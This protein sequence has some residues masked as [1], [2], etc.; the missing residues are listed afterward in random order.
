MKNAL[1]SSNIWKFYLASSLSYFIFFEPIIKIFFLSNDLTIFKIAMLGVIWNVTRLI[2]EVPSGIVADRWGRKNVLIISSL[3]AIL[4]LVVLINVTNYGGFIAAIILSS[5]SFAFLSGTDSAFFYDSLKEMKKEEEYEKLWARQ[6]IFKQI[7]LFIAFIASGFLFNISEV[8]PFQ[9]SLIF[10][11]LSLGIVFTYKEPKFTKHAEEANIFSHFTQA[12]SHIF[13]NPYLKTLMIFSLIYII[14]ADLSYTYGQIYLDH[15]MLPIIL[16][17]IVYTFK[18][19]FFTVA[20]NFAHK[21][22]NK[23]SYGNMFGLQLIM[24]IILLYAM[25]ITNN[26]IIGSL[27]FALIAVPYGFFIIL[28]SGYVNKH[29]KSHNRATVESM[30]SFLGALIIVVLEPIT[31]FLADLY[32]IKFPFLLVSFIMTLYAVYFLI[33]GR[34]R[35]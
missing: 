2:L 18:S 25:V 26:Y 21:L 17:G 4:Q 22:R 11:I 6:H 29:T 10:M 33:Y 15:L 23:Y 7:P 20:A 5:A 31:G 12:I 3:L 14:G 28:K 9:L 32:T 30:F 13:K 27:C 35:L 8:L 34:K 16:F 24:I 1:I 19:L